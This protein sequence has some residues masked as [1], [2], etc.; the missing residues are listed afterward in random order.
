MWHFPRGDPHTNVTRT[1]P[2]F[3]IKLS[4]T[5]QS[6]NLLSKCNSQKTVAAALHSCLRP[7]TERCAASAR[8][9][10]FVILNGLAVSETVVP[11]VQ[12]FP[13]GYALRGQHQL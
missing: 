1:T 13:Q 4:P 2:W 7:P 5:G 3:A 6:K 10:G 12:Y 8:T 11:M 9:V